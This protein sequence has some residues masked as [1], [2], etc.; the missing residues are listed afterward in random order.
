MRELEPAWPP[1]TFDSS[2][3]TSRPSEAPYTAAA[4]PAGPAPTIDEIA[5]AGVVDRLVE[6]EAV[7]NPRIG[8]ISQHRIAAADQHRDIGNA[9]LKTIEQL[10]R[11]AVAIEVD[12][13]KGMA[14][15]RQELLHAQR[16][17]AVRRADHDDVAQVPRNQ[18]EAAQ[19]ERPHQDLAQLR[20][21]SGSG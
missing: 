1:G 16:S 8:R 19:D 7:G 11:L 10:L 20:R 12:V 5:D 6:T 2:T 3:S 15:P 17:C 18:L 13:V 21:R 14:V 9:D 4:R